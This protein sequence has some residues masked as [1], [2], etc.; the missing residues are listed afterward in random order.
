MN[1]AMTSKWPAVHWSRVAGAAFPRRF[2]RHLC[3]W[4]NGL[5]PFPTLLVVL[6]SVFISVFFSVFISAG[7]AGP[8]LTEGPRG[9]PPWLTAQ[10]SLIVGQTRAQY[11]ASSGKDLPFQVRPRPGDSEGREPEEALAGTGVSMRPGLR[12][13]QPKTIQARLFLEKQSYGDGYLLLTWEDGRKETWKTIA[14]DLQGHPERTFDFIYTLATT[15]GKVAYLVLIGGKYGEGEKKFSGFEGTLI[16]PG[17]AHD[18]QR[19]ERAYKID[20]GYRFPDPPPH[21]RKV[22]EA[23]ELFRSL[24]QGVQ[25]LESLQGDKVT[26]EARLD[27]LRS[28]PPG[29]RPQ[30]NKAWKPARW[31]K[32]WRPCANA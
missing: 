14:H 18:L 26:Q 4:T 25:T 11:P 20:F 23:R 5:P 2:S 3:R 24:Q 6:F 22:N 13:R 9:M 1:R 21:Q 19:W 31:R 28:R 27:A 10:L 7:C 30:K 16:F 17:K 32:H 15:D 8:A 12:E 29:T